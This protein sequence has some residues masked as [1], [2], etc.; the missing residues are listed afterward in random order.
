MFIDNDRM[1]IQTIRE[2]LALTRLEERAEVLRTNQQPDDVM[3]TDV[4]ID[5]SKYD[6][7]AHGRNTL[8]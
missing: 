2:N 4:V 6:R 5:L 1:A 3:N 8:T 7:A